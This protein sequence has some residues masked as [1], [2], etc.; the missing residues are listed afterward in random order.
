M[1]PKPHINYLFV[2]RLQI[3]IFLQRFFGFIREPAVSNSVRRHCNLAMN[4]DPTHECD[5]PIFQCVHGLPGGCATKED[6]YGNVFPP[7]NYAPYD[8]AVEHLM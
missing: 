7:L 8:D 1:R 2:H 5:C 3:S 4:K 6:I